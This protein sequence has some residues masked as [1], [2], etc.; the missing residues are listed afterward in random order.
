MHEPWPDPFPFK[1]GD[2]VVKNPETWVVNDFDSWG[3]GIG[4]GVI[5]EPPFLLEDMGGVDVSWPYGRCFE[6]VAQ[7]LPAPKESE[8]ETKLE[9]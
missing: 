1:I 7:L 9:K 8:S 3:R 4:E 2:R 6:F 5:V